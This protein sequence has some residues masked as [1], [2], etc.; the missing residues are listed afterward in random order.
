[1]PRKLS[2]MIIITTVLAIS[3]LDSVLFEG[4]LSFFCVL[5]DWFWV[6][7]NLNTWTKYGSAEIIIIR[8]DLSK[9]WKSKKNLNLHFTVRDGFYKNV[10]I[11]RIIT[12]RKFI[13]IYNSHRKNIMQVLAIQF[14]ISFNK[15]LFYRKYFHFNIIFFFIIFVVF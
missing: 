10:Y 13:H 14:I 8:E 12:L 6:M 3:F 15:Q 5:P 1:M 2:I 4:K 11:S 9:N 7:L